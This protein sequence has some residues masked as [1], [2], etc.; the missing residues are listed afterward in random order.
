MSAKLYSISRKGD[1]AKPTARPPAQ[2]KVHIFSLGCAK[3]R[4]D[5]EV[6]LG[7]LLE[8]GLQPV[9]DAESADILI[10][11]TCGFIGDA[12]RESVEAI[13]EMAAV[14]AKAK[15]KGKKLVVTGCLSQVA[16]PEL[17]KDWPEVDAFLGTG[18]VEK[19]L[20][21]VKKTT[22][23]R[24]PKKPFPDPDFTLTA[25]SP[26]LLSLAY[27]AYVKISE[28]CSNACSFCSIPSMRGKQQS[29][30]LADVVAEVKNLRAAGV[31]EVNLIAQDLCAFGKDRG[32]GE[33]LADLLRAL[34]EIEIGDQPYWLRC[35]YAYPRGL[36]TE[37][38]SILA[39]AKHIVPYLD[40]P[41]QHASD[42]V[43]R[44]M[45]R[46]K[47]G[48]A[49][50]ELVERLREKH[51]KLTLRTTFLVG[52][53][54]ET[55]DDFKELV[56]FVK[57]MR[58]E[59]MGVFSYSPEDVTPSAHMP[60]QVPHEVAEERRITLLELQKNISRKQHAALRGKTLEVLVEGVSEESELLLQGRHACQAPEVDGV[61][62]INDGT[63]NP[64]DV[65]KV[66]INQS[67]DYDLVGA[68]V[69]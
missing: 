61:T 29:R 18:D 2:A 65:V 20:A 49:T 26:R 5:S 43:L 54:G 46:G 14:K 13:A 39:N 24:A 52:F 28:G 9:G 68:I 19:I 34:D 6:M 42:N 37:V 63:A 25:A 10:V 55:K 44:R 64:G 23:T 1:R 22:A 33:T 69:G 30:S 41:L 58:F 3:N 53:P 47:G 4:V 62:Y 12:Q 8:G 27:S 32:K 60:D 59:R 17:A 56:Q 66:K 15:G 36:T 40:M 21:T 51:P 57:D 67:G 16:A 45:K 38:Q 48:P 31:V 11:N 50:R 7:H 35:L